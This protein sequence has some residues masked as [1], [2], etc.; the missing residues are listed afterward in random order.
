MFEWS[1]EIEINDIKSIFFAW[2]NSVHNQ[3][4]SKIGYDN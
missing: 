4:L 1:T 2:L 3:S